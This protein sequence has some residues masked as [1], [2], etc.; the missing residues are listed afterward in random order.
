MN[1]RPLGNSIPPEILAAVRRIEIRT[2]RLVDEVFSGEYHSVFK[3]TGMEFAEVR[4]YQ[5]GDR[6]TGAAVFQRVRPRRAT[7]GP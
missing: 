7:G 1:R 2:R 4:H 6:R 5:P 3:G